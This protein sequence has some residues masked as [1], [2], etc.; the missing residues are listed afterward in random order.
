MSATPEDPVYG[1]ASVTGREAACGDGDLGMH[2]G[3]IEPL[4]SV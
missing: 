2:V 3:P 1:V 4:G